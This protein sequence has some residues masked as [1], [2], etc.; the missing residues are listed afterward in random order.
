MPGTE[1]TLTCLGIGGFRFLD[2]FALKGVP[3]PYRFDNAVWQVDG[4]RQSISKN[5]WTTEIT[6]KVRPLTIIQ[7]KK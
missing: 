7:Q 4:V 3:K 2:L 6:A 1:M 5:Y